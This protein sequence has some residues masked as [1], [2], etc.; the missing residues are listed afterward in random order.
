MADLAAGALVSDGA[1]L[2]LLGP[3]ERGSY[4]LLTGNLQEDLGCRINGSLIFL[5]G[6]CDL[7]SVGTYQKGNEFHPIIFERG[8]LY[9]TA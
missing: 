7:L 5:H 8:A 3:V 4:V 6:R 9:K 1:G 2:Q